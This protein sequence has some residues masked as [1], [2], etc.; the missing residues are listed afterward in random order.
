MSKSKDTTGQ[1]VDVESVSTSDD[2]QSVTRVE[3]AH[4]GT[5]LGEPA[6]GIGETTDPGVNTIQALPES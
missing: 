4:P 1:D 6:P 2:Q 5:T 3:G